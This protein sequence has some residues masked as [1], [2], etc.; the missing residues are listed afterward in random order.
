[1][2]FFLQGHKKTRVDKCPQDE[3]ILFRSSVCQHGDRSGEGDNI[4]KYLS[5]ILLLVSS[6]DLQE[7]GGK[8]VVLRFSLLRW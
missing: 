7:R 3:G 1:M 4:L 8:F 2:H 6:N 5:I